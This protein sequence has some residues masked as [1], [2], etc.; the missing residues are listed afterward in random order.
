M[1]QATTSYTM[2]DERDIFVTMRDGV[3]IGLRIYRPDTQGEFP[4]LFAASPY[5]YDTD[6]LPSLPLF[7]WRETGPV[8]WYVQRGYA[9]VRMDVRGSGNSEGVYGYM[10][11]AE[12]QDCV[13]VI[14][15]IAQ[16]PWSNGKS[17]ATGSRTTR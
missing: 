15:W 2:R 9:Y 7:L 16:Q 11:P 1:T 14:E 12:Q 4:T 10:D 8:E 17:V 13:E 5:Q 3:R 6:G